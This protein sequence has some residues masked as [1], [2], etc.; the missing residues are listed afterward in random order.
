VLSLAQPGHLRFY[1]WEA[2]SLTPG[3]RVVAGRIAAQDPA[4]LTISQGIGESPPGLPGTGGLPLYDAVRLASHRRP[5][6][7]RSGLSRP[8]PAYYLFGDPGSPACAAAARSGGAR[9]V[10]GDHCLLAGPVSRARDLGAGLPAGVTVS[11]GRRLTVAQGTVVLQAVGSPSGQQV[12]PSSPAAQFFVLRDREALDGSEVVDP[13]PGTNAAGQLDVAFTFTPAGARAF[14]AVTAVE[15]HRGNAVSLPGQELQQHFAVALDSALVTVP[16]IDFRIYP[17]GIASAG[18]DITGGLTAQ[19]A[20][21]L[22]LVLSSHPLSVALVPAQ[23][24]GG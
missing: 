19:S 7:A 11:A 8:G 14:H 24:T 16:A 13:R 20:R 10:P 12:D 5:V 6:R 23:A 4:A 21:D 17:D 15:A 9:P 2:D 1:D 22:S 18:A 3:G